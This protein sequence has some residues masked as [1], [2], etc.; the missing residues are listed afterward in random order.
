T[1][2]VIVNVVAYTLRRRQSLEQRRRPFVAQPA[3]LG[4]RQPATEDPHEHSFPP[5]LLFRARVINRRLGF[6]ARAS[7]RQF[8]RFFQSAELIDQSQFLGLRSGVDA[9]VGELANLR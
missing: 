6:D 3:A 5:P 7:R 2:E 9:A 8:Y 1:Q 4:S